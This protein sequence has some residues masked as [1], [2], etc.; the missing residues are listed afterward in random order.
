VSD[1]DHVTDPTARGPVDADRA[2]ARAPADRAD[3][4]DDAAEAGDEAADPADAA[5]EAIAERDRLRRQADQLAAV[6][7]ERGEL[8]ERVERLEIGLAGERER[9]QTLRFQRDRYRHQVASMRTRRWWRLGAAIADAKRTPAKLLTLPI[10]LLRVLFGPGV[11]P[12]VPPPLPP[13]EAQGESADISAAQ[14][15]SPTETRPTH[16]LEARFLLPPRARAVTDLRIAAIADTF[17]EASF[18]P[19]CDLITFRPDTWRAALEADRPHLLF[20]ESAWKGNGG[21]WEFQVGS[22]TYPESV[23]LPHLAELVDH[24][25]DHDI[26]TVFWNKEDPV[27]F[28]K[29]KEAARLF[30]VVLTTDQDRIPAYEALDGARAQVVAALPFAAQPALHHPTHE[31][32]DRDPRPVFGGT[33]YKNR[34]PER[35]EQMEQLLDA[36]REFDLVIYDRT[37]GQESESVGFPDRFQPHVHGGVPYDEMVRIYREHRLFLNTNSVIASPTMFSRRVFELLACGTP[38]VSTPSLGVE[39]LFGGIVPVIDNGPDAA[40]AIRT[41]LTDDAAWQATSLAGMRAVLGE[42]TYQHRLARI[43]ALCGF[44]VTPY[45]DRRATVLLLDDDRDR[46]RGLCIELRAAH[47]DLEV[48][49]GTDDP[50]R[51][52]DLAVATVRQAAD[53]SPRERWRELASR[54]DTPFVVV[55]DPL[56]TPD[57]LT[58]LVRGLVLTDA[59]AVG[60]APGGPAW[61]HVDRVLTAPLAVRRSHVAEHGWDVEV[62]ASDALLAQLAAG[63]IRA[64][65]LGDPGERVPAARAATGA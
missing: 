62:A 20:V 6:L 45:A 42:H 17:T 48:A 24:C 4:A 38:V 3:A 27:H 35:R 19:D 9:N 8:T 5:A 56:A 37:H 13:G 40:D 31:L 29:F 57:A 52:A 10:A 33:Y 14:L 7:H 58:D 34:H 1:H 39:Q 36:A 49:V 61:R 32:A 43:A 11:K 15:R 50:S 65:S 59:P 64:Y 54:V 23:G 55:A 41:L 18:A 2:D 46:V 30:D 28:D 60:F 51:F 12:D 47:S 21:S 25:N 16:H 44:E 53:T 22:Y 26:P 63:G